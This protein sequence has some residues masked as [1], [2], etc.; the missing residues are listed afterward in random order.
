MVRLLRVLCEPLAPQRRSLRRRSHLLYG[1]SPGNQPVHSPF[2]E[3]R[4]D[5]SLSVHGQPNGPRTKQVSTAIRR[6]SGPRHTHPR[7]TWPERGA[8]TRYTERPPTTPFRVTVG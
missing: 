7:S 3:R 8:W 6:A 2:N 5:C 4:T 1:R